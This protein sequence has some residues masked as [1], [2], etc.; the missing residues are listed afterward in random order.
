MAKTS[1]NRCLGE[2]GYYQPAKK[3]YE[4]KRTQHKKRGDPRRKKS[5]E[6]GG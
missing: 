3:T 5:G 4:G 1:R 2:R 6:M